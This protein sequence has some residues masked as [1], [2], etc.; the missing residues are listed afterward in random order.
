[1]LKMIIIAAIAV[2]IG[3]AF[4]ALLGS[5]RSCETG[6]CPLTATPWRGG[7]YGGFVGLLL[8][9]SLLTQ[10]AS[11]GESP[12]SQKGADMTTADLTQTIHL[13]ES[14]F[15]SAT[16]KGLALIDFWAPWCGPCRML[17][18]VIDQLAASTGND[19]LV[20]KVNVDDSPGLAQRF[21]VTGIPCMVL[22][23]DGQ[24]VDRK[25]GVQQ[26]A[27]LQAWIESHR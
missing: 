17:G 19:V 16:T 24:E 21:N 22:L 13:D 25:V 1:M 20:G 10:P 11:A 9:L 5:T 3:A 14:S 2:A 8:A 23:K 15:D 27:A 18:P 6:A 26:A 12:A 4:G 7:I